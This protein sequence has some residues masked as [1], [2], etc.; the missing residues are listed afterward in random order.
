MRISRRQVPAS[1]P[2][3]TLD[4]RR[5]PL[6]HR[7]RCSDVRVHCCRRFDDN[8][9]DYPRHLAVRGSS[10]KRGIALIYA[11]TRPLPT[12]RDTRSSQL[13]KREVSGSSP[14]VGSLFTATLLHPVGASWPNCCGRQ[15]NRVVSE[16]VS[17]NALFRR[18]LWTTCSLPSLLRSLSVCAA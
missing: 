17:L 15:D 11:G 16:S 10:M 9:T 8:P 3:S 7:R 12:I 1:W 13:V 14:L 18:L 2:T 5:T 4:P 6:R